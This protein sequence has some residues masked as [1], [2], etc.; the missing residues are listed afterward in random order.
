LSHRPAPDGQAGDL[1]TVIASVLHPGRCL[2]S[3]GHNTGENAVVLSRHRQPGVSLDNNVVERALK[4]AILHRKNSLF[5]KTR[6]GAQMGDLF[7]SLIHTCELNDVKA[8]DYLTEL[9]RHL[10]EHPK[11]ATHD[12]LKTGHLEPSPRTLTRARGQYSPSM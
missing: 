1:E 2:V 3:F 10:G 5:Y 7:M 11:P 4:K 6:K 9:L 8:F 12:H